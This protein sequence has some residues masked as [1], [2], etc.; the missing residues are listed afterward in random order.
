MSP[1]EIVEFWLPA[2]DSL[3]K[4]PF[5]PVEASAVN[6]YL[7]HLLNIKVTDHWWETLILTPEL[8]RKL[9]HIDGPYGNIFLKIL[10]V[11]KSK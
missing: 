8:K 3:M 5:D 10:E 11:R 6:N 1:D 4:E 7:T 9:K 2:R